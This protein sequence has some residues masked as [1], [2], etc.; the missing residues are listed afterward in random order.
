MIEIG[1]LLLK[2]KNKI[3]SEELRI[4]IIIDVI[5]EITKTTIEKKDIKIK[6]G[7]IILNNKPIV[8]NEIFL[9]KEKILVELK[10]LLGK[11][12]PQNIN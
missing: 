12:A 3:L 2:S 5:T 8:R 7:T 6:N 11:K 10:N 1:D 4:K 9:K